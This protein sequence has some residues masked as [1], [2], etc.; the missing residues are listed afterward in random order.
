MRGDLSAAVAKL[1]LELLPGEF[2]LGWEK[3]ACPL[4]PPPYDVDKDVQGVLKPS[5]E[6]GGEDGR[7]GCRTQLPGRSPAQVSWRHVP[8]T[9]LWQVGDPV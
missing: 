2:V 5:A 6:D 8:E 9:R 1:L 7:R 3:V 4:L